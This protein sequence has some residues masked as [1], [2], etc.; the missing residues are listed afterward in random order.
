MGSSP[1]AGIKARTAR[2]GG[3]SLYYKGFKEL[4]DNK[5]QPYLVHL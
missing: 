3:F 5:I 4:L 1:T 2:N